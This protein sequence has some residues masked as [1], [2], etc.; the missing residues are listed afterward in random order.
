M[1]RAALVGRKLYDDEFY[2]IWRID[3]QPAL[4]APQGKDG[5]PGR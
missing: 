3:R 4:A 1:S 5:T 2:S